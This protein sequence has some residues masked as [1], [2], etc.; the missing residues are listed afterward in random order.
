MLLKVLGSAAGGGFPQWNCGC[1]NCRR[2]RMQDPSLRARLHNSLAVS[3]DGS[4]WV[5]INATPDIGAQIEA[6][7]ELAPGS[8]IRHTPISTVLL[9]DGELDHTMGL[10]HLR[11]S[12][13]I[14]VYAAAPVLDALMEAFPVRRIL[15][16]YASYRWHEVRPQESFPLFGGRVMVY[17]FFLGS[18]PPRYASV[19]RNPHTDGA[20]TSPW[21]V[22]YRMV[23]Q[24]T[25][26]TAVYA[27]GVES[28]S[29]EL[30]TELEAADGV[31]VDGTFWHSDEL[32][33]LDISGLVASDMGHVPIAGPGGSLEHLSRLSAGRKIY[34][35]INNTNPILDEAS[36]E[37]RSLR[38][39]GIE[40]G[41][42]GLELEV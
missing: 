4:D 30:H 9:T 15:E 3:D 34:I 32:R 11:E 28:W 10:L 23:D 12:S 14:D 13:A 27:P 31:L 26:G 22:G 41:Y 35:H 38:E 17:P 21:V 2:V 8:T 18:K 36:A 16:P 24:R 5:L 42:D 25:G 19:L 33:R 6:H 37:N 40:V 20:P 7:A 29:N 39:L 1:P